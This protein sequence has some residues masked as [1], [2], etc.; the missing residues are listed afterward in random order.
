M[1]LAADLYPGVGLFLRKLSGQSSVLHRCRQRE[2]PKA[3]SC[4]LPKAGSGPRKSFPGV[5]AI[6]A[7]LP[8]G[9]PFVLDSD[10]T[11][12]DASIPP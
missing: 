2:V 1:E 10:L 12:V 11:A 6:Q 4:A 3:A 7:L 5:E 8:A 9:K